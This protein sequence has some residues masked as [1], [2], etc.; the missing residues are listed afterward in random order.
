[1]ILYKVIERKDPRNMEAPGKW[2]AVKFGTGSVGVP[3][4][5]AEVAEH[6]GQSEGTV[7]GLLRDLLTEM[8]KWLL[9]GHSVRLGEIGVFSLTLNGSGSDTRED[10]DPSNVTR[11]RVRFTPSADLKSSTS[12]VARAPGSGSLFKRVPGGGPGKGGGEED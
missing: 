2:Y 5:A 11:V 9:L 12:L 1:M 8:Q 10:Y 3:R 7:T 4:L 6:A